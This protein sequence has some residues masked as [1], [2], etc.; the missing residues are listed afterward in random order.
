MVSL[1]FHHTLG[2]NILRV[3]IILMAKPQGPEAAGAS[4]SQQLGAPDYSADEQRR[5][6]EIET[7]VAFLSV[8]GPCRSVG[9][10]Y[11]AC[12]AVAGLGQCRHLRAKFESCARNNPQS[13]S[14]LEDMSKQ[15]FPNAEDPIL[16]AARM[17]NQQHMPPKRPQNEAPGL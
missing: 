11:L 7:A 10:I 8:S 9:D 16:Y 17:V 5:L 1:L 4:S 13:K 15:M 12:V 6:S 14:Y 2:S 3:Y